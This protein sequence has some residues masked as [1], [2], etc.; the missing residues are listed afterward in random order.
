MLPVPVT[1]H[2]VTVCGRAAKLVKCEECGLEYVYLYTALIDGESASVAYLGTGAAREQAAEVANRRL[3]G[4][5]ER[6]GSVVPCLRCGRVQEHMV[7]LA[8]KGRHRRLFYAGVFALMAAV[9]LGG[10][11]ALALAT[12]GLVGPGGLTEGAGLAAAFVALLL[13]GAWLLRHRRRLCAR[14]DPNGE[15]LEQRKAHGRL[16]AWTKE[17][18]SAALAPP[19]GPA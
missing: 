3:A 7:A 6:G 11:T 2:V 16:R 19:E 17:E 9:P 18:F 5:L 4:A 8:R 12:E 10:M 15:P 13:G 14:Y 1:Q